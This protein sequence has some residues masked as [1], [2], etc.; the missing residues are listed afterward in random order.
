MSTK[1]HDNKQSIMVKMCLSKLPYKTKSIAEFA[2]S[3]GDFAYYNTT[4][5]IYQC[6][7]CKKWHIGNKSKEGEKVVKGDKIRRNS[8]TFKEKRVIRKMRY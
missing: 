8:L 2:L 7:F 3:N 1:E 5:S 6:S 4:I